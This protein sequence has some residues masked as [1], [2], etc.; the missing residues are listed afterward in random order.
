MFKDL[1]SETHAEKTTQSVVSNVQRHGSGFEPTCDAVTRVLHGF[2]LMRY[3]LTIEDGQATKQWQYIQCL[4]LTRLIR[5]IQSQLP[6]KLSWPIFVI[7]IQHHG[8]CSSVIILEGI[9][10]FLVKRAGS[11]NGI[12]EFR[13]DYAH[14]TGLIEVLY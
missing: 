6:T 11:I 8:K 9:H 13:L 10:M 1:C 4:L 14:V 5:H 7:Q 2:D 3:G 12:M